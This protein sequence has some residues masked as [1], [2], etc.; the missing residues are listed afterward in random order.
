MLLINLSACA[1]QGC[2]GCIIMKD[3]IPI[4]SPI[5]CGVLFIKS[6]NQS[7]N[8]AVLLRGKLGTCSILMYSTA[9]G[10]CTSS[11]YKLGELVYHD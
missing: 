1:V 3:F 9:C 7:A 2:F 10:V 4:P 5:T 6:G 8:Y 11:L